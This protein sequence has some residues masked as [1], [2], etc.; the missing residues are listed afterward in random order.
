MSAEM[1]YRMA[2]TASLAAVLLL[3]IVIL[4]R[5]WQRDREVQEQ[6][7]HAQQL[8]LVD[9]LRA[10]REAQMQMHRDTLEAVHAVR[11]ALREL[12]GAIK[13]AR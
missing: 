3:G 4:W 8:A 5:T 7:A 6:R 12:H 11:D 10:A 2:E 13:E 9:E 1:L